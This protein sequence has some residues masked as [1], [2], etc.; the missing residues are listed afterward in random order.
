MNFNDFLMVFNEL[1]YIIL[2]YI[3]LY[4]IILHYI[5]HGHGH[6]HGTI[7]NTWA[8]RP[9]HATHVLKTV[10]FPHT[11]SKPNTEHD[12]VPFLCPNQKPNTTHNG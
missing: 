11:A 4:Y 3:T 9:G 7:I 5:C 12:T 1:Y 10:V 2:H 8:R 6:G